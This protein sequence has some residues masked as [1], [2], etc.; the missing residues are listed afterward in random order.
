M[1]RI[2]QADDDEYRQHRRRRHRHAVAQHAPPGRAQVVLAPRPEQGVRRD[3][4]RDQ[5]EEQRV[6]PEHRTG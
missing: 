3:D 6:G 5:H 2:E 4:G 1:Q